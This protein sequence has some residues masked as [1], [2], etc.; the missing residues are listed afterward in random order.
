MRKVLLLSAAFLL[1]VSNLA[2]SQDNTGGEGSIGGI[3]G[4]TIVGGTVAAGFVAA[5]ISN[6]RGTDVIIPGPTECPDGEELQNGQCV[7]VD[8][9]TTVTGTTTV[10]GTSTG[11][12]T[13]S[14]TSTGS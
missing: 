2:M 11:T 7:P 12:V 10:P 14:V 9:T 8:S 3:T 13:V 1:S 5:V 4:G 6:T